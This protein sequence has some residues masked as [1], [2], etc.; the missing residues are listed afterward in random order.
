MTRRD[1]SGENN[2]MYKHGLKGTRLYNI[3]HSMKQRCHYSLSKDYQRYG[4]RGITICDEWENDF[5][6][7]YNWAMRNGYNSNLTLDRI[8]VNGNYEPSNCRW[9]SIKDQN[10]NRR[11]CKKITYNGETHNLTQWALILGIN[12]NTLIARLNKG[13]PIKRAFSESVHKEFSSR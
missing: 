10:N 2:P 11:S 3:W 6:S 13:W 1:L 4:G 8:D 12:K 5:M 7:F 9:V